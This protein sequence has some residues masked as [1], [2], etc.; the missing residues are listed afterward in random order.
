MIGTG[1]GVSEQVDS[2]ACTPAFSHACKHL[3][4]GSPVASCKSSPGSSRHH[5]GRAV[6]VRVA[7]IPKRDVSEFARTLG[8]TGVGYYPNSTFTHI[9]V[10]DRSYYWI[11]RS[12]PGQRARYQRLSD[13][14]RFSD[15][16]RA[17]EPAERPAERP[18]EEPTEGRTASAENDRE[19]N[20]AQSARPPIDWEVDFE[21]GRTSAA[22]VEGVRSVQL[23]ESEARELRESLLNGIRAAAREQGQD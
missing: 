23:S 14:E 2:S 7:G 8:G 16:N 9:D 5:S 12:A 10:R 3:L 13:S 15:A 18:V 1:M 21:A 20:P 6:D 19:T 22:P 17:V 11:D 4:K